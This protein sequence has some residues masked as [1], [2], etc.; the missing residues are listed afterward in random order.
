[1]LQAASG[2]GLILGP[3]LCGI[4]IESLSNITP[5]FAILGILGLLSCL[6]L[7]LQ[8][9]DIQLKIKIFICSLLCILCLLTTIFGLQHIP[10]QKIFQKTKPQINK[11]SDTTSSQPYANLAMG[12]I[13]RLQLYGEPQK[14]DLAARQAFA[15]IAELEKDFGHRTAYGSIGKINAAAGKK[16][17]IVTPQAFSLLERAIEIGK[18]TNGI[19]DI[20][21]GT[22]TILP[23]YY[24]Q[25][26]SK[27]KKQLVDYTKIRL[28]PKT[29]TVFLPQ[30][31]MALDV[32]GL[33]KGSII[34]AAAETIRKYGIRTALIE[35]NGDFFCYGEKI[36]RIGIQDPRS[37][38]LLGVIEVKNA[39]V[40]GSGDYY[41]YSEDENGERNHHILNPKNL[42]SARASIGVTTIAPTAELADALATTLFITGPQKGIKLLKNFPNC[43]A[44]W[45]KPDKTLVFSPNFPKF[46][47]TK[48]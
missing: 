48:K 19:F 39:G 1:M 14:T 3:I 27:E 45:V 8:L 17:V 10:I 5:A 26:A 12:G 11:S 41:Q 33:A 30:K 4:I 28:E 47:P 6:P 15:T 23:Y 44:L 2:T 7:A 38:E 43:S 46:I 24:R 36:W 9:H 20:S 22:V 34:D 16:S 29:Q 40:C 35:G 31:G 42:E 25:K 32:G 13:I 18:K 37:S 21:I